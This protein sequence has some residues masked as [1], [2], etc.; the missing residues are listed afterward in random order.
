MVRLFCHRH[1]WE[2]FKWISPKVRMVSGEISGRQSAIWPEPSTTS[3]ASSGATPQ[4]SWWRKRPAWDSTTMT[5]TFPT[6]QWN[7][8]KTPTPKTSSWRCWRK[9]SFGGSMVMRTKWRELWWP[10]K[11]MGPL[12]PRTVSMWRTAA[13]QIP[14]TSTSTRTRTPR[15][16]AQ[17][18][19]S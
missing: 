6:L 13:R 10:S 1:G 19:S 2:L 15:R 8:C 11:V 14:G 9:T 16:P 12:G 18:G 17:T 4:K 3:L 7:A 5:R